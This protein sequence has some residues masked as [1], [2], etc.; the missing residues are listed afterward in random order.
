M[1]DARLK[2]VV[3]DQ[4]SSQTTSQLVDAVLAY[5]LPAMDSLAVL[6]CSVLT[7]ELMGIQIELCQML[8]LIG[9]KQLNWC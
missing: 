6:F 3:V 1:N 4:L 9:P 8:I 2:W 5:N 7:S